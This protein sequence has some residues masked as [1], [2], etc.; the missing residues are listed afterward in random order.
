ML[1]PDPSR[2]RRDVFDRARN[3]RPS[4]PNFGLPDPVGSVPLYQD[5]VVEQG[6]LARDLWELGRRLGG[7]STKIGG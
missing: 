6:Q 7:N 2:N 5:V 4:E 3:G 1:T